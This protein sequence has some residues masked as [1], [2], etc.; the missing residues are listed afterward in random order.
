M[1]ALIQLI[2]RL[3]G[4]YIWIVLIAVILSWLVAFQ[5]INLRH[6]F[7]NQVVGFIYMLTEPLFSFVR[8]FLPP[9]GGFDLSPIVVLLGLYFLRDLLWDVARGFYG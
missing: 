6:P 4:I 3:I 8:R 7:I 5:I 1:F 9:L 2:D